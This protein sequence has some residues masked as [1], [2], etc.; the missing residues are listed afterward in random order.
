MIIIGLF[1]VHG[2]MPGEFVPTGQ[3]VNKHFYLG[4]LRRLWEDVW[5]KHSEL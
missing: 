5:G 1:G 2:I 4:A 3:T